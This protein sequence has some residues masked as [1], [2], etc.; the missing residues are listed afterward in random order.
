MNNILLRTCYQQFGTK[1]SPIILLSV[2]AKN[3]IRRWFVREELS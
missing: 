2:D 1:T 3:D